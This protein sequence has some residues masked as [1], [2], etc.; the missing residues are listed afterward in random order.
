MRR[1]L[2]KT[3]PPIAAWPEEELRYADSGAFCGFV[4]PAVPDA[5]PLSEFLNP[6]ARRRVEQKFG[7]SFGPRDLVVIASNLARVVEVVHAQSYVIGDI[8]ESNFL[9]NHVGHVCLI[10]ADSIQVREPGGHV[11]RCLVGTPRFTAPELQTLAYDSIDRS[12]QHDRF[13]LAVLAFMLLMRG[14]HPLRAIDRSSN[15]PRS[16]QENI[17]AGVYP[18]EGGFAGFDAPVHAPPIESLGSEVRRAFDRT[19]VDGY[20][21]PSQRVTAT[22]WVQILE[23]LATKLV[24]CSTDDAHAFHEELGSCPTCARAAR[25]IPAFQQRTLAPAAP[26]RGRAPQPAQSTATS[27]WSVSSSN[28]SWSSVP[29]TKPVRPTIGVLAVEHWRVTVGV[30]AALLSAVAWWQS[31]G[32]LGLASLG[33]AAIATAWSNDSHWPARWMAGLASLSNVLLFGALGV[34]AVVDWWTSRSADASAFVDAPSSASPPVLASPRASQPTPAVGSDSACGAFDRAAAGIT[35]WSS[36]TC[37]SRA[38]VGFGW[39]ECLRWDR[40]AANVAGGCPGATRCCPP[41]LFAGVVTSPAELCVEDDR[42]P[43]HVHR[44]ASSGSPTV[45]TLDNGSRVTATDTAQ[46]WTRIE[47]PVAGWVWTPWLA[48]C[49]GQAQPAELP[50][51][52]PTST[53][54]GE[55]V[56]RVARGFVEAGQ[57]E[58]ALRALGEATR[59]GAPPNEVDAVRHDLERLGAN[60]VGFRIV[61]GDCARARS[62]FRR[63]DAE[64]LGA[65]AREQFTSW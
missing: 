55:L 49:E 2:P 28:A 34:G 33:C 27:S 32:L 59:A 24:V 20:R 19:F 26:M 13:G 7:R 10:D 11:H 25:A 52:R 35:G 15:A 51:D 17:D 8:N 23:R 44:D 12:V 64:G 63:L 53:D 50:L 58:D 54:S 39:D 48:W 40:Y 14:Q 4:M 42:P 37:R 60:V 5:E 36:Y 29:V 65:A 57:A 30:L 56:L 45:A 16:D 47:T 61:Q 3:T 62:L 21:N 31:A 38:E 46:E 43:L 1:P 41:G 22:E 18:Y 9:V 6:S